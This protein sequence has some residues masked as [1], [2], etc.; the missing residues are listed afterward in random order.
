M[1]NLIATGQTLQG[2]I[3]SNDGDI[4]TLTTNL[5]ST[6]STV[7]ANLITSGQ[8]LTTNLASTG[9]TVAANLVTSGQTLTT[10]LASTGNTLVTDLASTGATVAANLVTSGQYLTSEVGTLSGLSVF[11]SMT[12]NFATH[13][14][15][16]DDIYLAGNQGK[17]LK[18]NSAGDGL[19][20]DLPPVTGVGGEGGGATH[21]TGLVDT[22]NGY[23]GIGA[24]PEDGGLVVFNAT[25]EQI[26]Y[27]S[28]GA[29]ASDADLISSGNTLDSKRDVLSGNLISS[30]NV[31]DAARDTLS[32]NLI[33]TGNN[34]E[35][36]II[37]ND[38]DIVTLTSNLVS[39]GN[40]LDSQRDTLSGNSNFDR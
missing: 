39:T 34:L 29:F 30:G 36:Q 8:T 11:H 13:F 35:N 5:A 10:N 37:S 18:V 19:S 23:S 1:P 7:A 27:A 40:T 12:G 2:Q 4:V 26:A 20:Y 32:G 16:L 28:S 24:L 31:L 15:N 33:S 25:S 6:G 21:F 9:T 22:P 38:G 3:T 17:Y 14:H